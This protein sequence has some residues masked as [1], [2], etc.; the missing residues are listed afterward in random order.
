MTRENG[1][2]SKIIALPPIS[3]T[4]HIRRYMVA[5]SWLTFPLAYF[6][7]VDVY[8]MTSDGWLACPSLHYHDFPC[9]Q[10]H[11]YRIQFAILT[12]IH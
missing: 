7:P 1:D 9:F 6:I 10:F 2:I 11:A 3:V 5:S 8:F 4:S 12:L